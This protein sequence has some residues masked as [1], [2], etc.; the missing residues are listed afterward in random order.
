MLNSCISRMVGAVLWV[1]PIGI[2][3]LIAASI[4]NACDLLQTLSGLGL[5]VLTVLLGLT[6]FAAVILPLLLWAVT[7]TSP[8]K[9]LRTFSQAIV[10]AFGTSSSSAALPVKPS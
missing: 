4:V 5:W 8:L 1:S 7:R 9:F 3:S 2:A 10:L 6:V